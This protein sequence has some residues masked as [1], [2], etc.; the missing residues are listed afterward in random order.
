MPAGLWRSHAEEKRFG[1]ALHDVAEFEGLDGAGPVL[2]RVE[3][4]LEAGDD[5]PANQP[6]EVGKRGEQGEHQRGGDDTRG[7]QL[8]RGV[9]AHG[10]HGVHLLGDEHGAELG[11]DAGSVASGNEQAG[12]GGAQFADQ[13]DGHD[14]A[15][16]R[17][18]AEPRELGGGLQDKDGADEKT[19][20]ENDG[21]G[22]DADEVHLLKGVSAIAGRGENVGDGAEGEQGVVLHGLDAVLERV[23]DDRKDGGRALGVEN[24]VGCSHE[25]AREVGLRGNSESV[26]FEEPK[27]KRSREWKR[28]ALARLEQVG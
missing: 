24:R 17:G 12:D 27:V 22:A 5:E 20:Q 21:E 8:A 9:G 19:G 18:G 1:H 14:V 6:D 16:E 26:A 4:Q 13:G 15:G 28:R 11:G 3:A 10:A 7:D 25:I 2:D 23:E